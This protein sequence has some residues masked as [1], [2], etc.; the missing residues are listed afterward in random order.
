MD[1]TLF[2]D[3]KLTFGKF[4]GSRRVDPRILCPTGHGIFGRF[5][6]SFDHARFAQLIHLRR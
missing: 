6:A 4:L 3:Q 2:G 1:T 5:G